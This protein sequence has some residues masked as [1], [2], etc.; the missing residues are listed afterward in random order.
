MRI[1]IIGASGHGK[2]TLAEVIKQLTNVECDV[3]NTQDLI[4]I[5]KLQQLEESLKE[6]TIGEIKEFKVSDKSKH[7]KKGK[8]IK[9]WQ[10]TKFYQR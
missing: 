1:V 8:E 9:T 7:R 3:V 2:S 5:N 10:R 6:K 4:E